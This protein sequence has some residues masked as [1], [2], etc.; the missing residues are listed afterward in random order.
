MV[1]FHLAY[2]A[3]ANP[4]GAQPVLTQ[5]QL[6]AGF[7]RKV[8]KPWEFVPAIEKAEVLSDEG[9]VVTRLVTF[10]PGGMGQAKEVCTILAPSRVDYHLENGSSVLNVISS[11]P[12]GA[13]EDLFVTY[14]F[15]WK[16][17]DIEEGSAKASEVF[18]NHKKVC[19][20]ALPETRKLIPSPAQTSTGSSSDSFS[21]TGGQVSC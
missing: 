3:P 17:D 12:S 19:F 11:G 2:T 10:K 4:A 14:I 9:N 7:Q 8:R 21:N 6:F 16:H 15:D 5:A 13:P 1:S 18:E 20:F